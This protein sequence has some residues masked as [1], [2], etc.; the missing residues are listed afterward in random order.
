MSYLQR[1][2]AAPNKDSVKSLYKL[3]LLCLTFCPNTR[4]SGTTML[5]YNFTGCF[6]IRREKRKQD[7]ST[8]FPKHVRLTFH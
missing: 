2:P 8:D 7:G 3:N 6:I 4:N 1:A 5:K